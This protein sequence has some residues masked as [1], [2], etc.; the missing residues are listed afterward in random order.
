MNAIKTPKDADLSLNVDKLL[1]RGG[2]GVAIAI[3]VWMN[4]NLVSVRNDV[5]GL[6]ES[7]VKVT[8][9]LEL[10]APKEVQ[11]AVLNLERQMLRRDD[12]ERI[13]VTTAPWVKD[14][15]H[16]EQ[17]LRDLERQVEELRAK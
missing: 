6:K 7:V 2:G 5:S 14:K 10:V 9:E 4:T 17:R 15:T 13:I 16:F 11:A 12:V 1:T 3:L 8:T